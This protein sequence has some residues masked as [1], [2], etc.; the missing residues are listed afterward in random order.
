MAT[1]CEWKRYVGHMCYLPWLLYSVKKK[2]NGRGRGKKE[3]KR[4]NEWT[5]REETPYEKCGET[6]AFINQN[7]KGL[8]SWRTHNIRN[9]CTCVCILL[10]WLGARDFVRE[11][12]HKCDRLLS[13]DFLQHYHPLTNVSVQLIHVVTSYDRPARFYTR[14]WMNGFQF[15]LQQRHRGNYYI[16]IWYFYEKNTE[17]FIKTLVSVHTPTNT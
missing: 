4:K 15:E 11:R 7:S 17:L 10:V 2:Y 14:I 16:F 13:H 9:V 1:A 3:K 6:F 12:R 5:Q 8:N